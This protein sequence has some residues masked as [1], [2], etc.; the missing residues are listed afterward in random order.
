MNDTPQRTANDEGLSVAIRRTIRHLLVIK[1][2]LPFIKAYDEEIRFRIDLKTV[3]RRNEGVYQAMR[4]SYD[5]LVI[6]LAS[7]REGMVSK[8]GVL[9]QLA[10]HLELFQPFTWNNVSHEPA[11]LA[12]PMPIDG[13]EAVERWEREQKALYLNQALKRLFPGSPPVT[14]KCVPALIKRF[15]DETEPMMSDRNRV[16]AHRY[17][18]AS[19][20]PSFFQTIPSVESQIGVFEQYLNDLYAV[21]ENG[22]YSM[23]PP[24]RASPHT[25]AQDLVDLVQHG[26]IDEATRVYG[27][28]EENPKEPLRT[29]FHFLR[30]RYWEDA[31]NR[32]KANPTDADATPPEDG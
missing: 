6:D 30:D 22:M 2:R 19:R 24:L 32:A 18:G 17:E 4:D 15:R 13:K 10:K 16:R 29:F 12:S 27:A 5:M 28:I 14:E 26:S 9:N 8:D 3:W 31:A 21:T 1:S 11:G 20:D 25:T 7:L 23:E